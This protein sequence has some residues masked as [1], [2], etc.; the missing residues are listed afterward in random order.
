MDG[1]SMDTGVGDTRRV[2]TGQIGLQQIGPAPAGSEP[3]EG[4]YINARGLTAAGPEGVVF[5][6]VEVLA[7]PGDLVAV[8]GPAG[9]GRTSLLLALSGRLRVVAGYLDV[10][11]HLLPKGARAVRRLIAPA[12]LRPG[13][14]LE[15]LHLVREAVQERLIISDLAERRIDEAFHL[16][17]IDPHPDVLVADLHPA[18]Q[19]LLAVALAV[20]DA[21]AGLLVDDVDAGLPA[22]ASE[23]VWSAL[24][25][26]TETGITVITSSVDPPPFTDGVALVRLP[27]EVW[28]DD[29]LLSDSEPMFFS[30]STVPDPPESREG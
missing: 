29:E 1:L 6:N 27:F 9:S 14:E 19:V 30:G 10:S 5:E 12:R 13:C 21:P 7:D 20:A 23:R 17:G 3:L 26:V 22:E 11:G 28:P 15:E 8:V 16:V 25:A 18:D 2:D 24:R 4:V